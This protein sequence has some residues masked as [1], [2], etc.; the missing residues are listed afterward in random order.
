MSSRASKTAVG[1]LPGVWVWWVAAVDALIVTPIPTIWNAWVTLVDRLILALRESVLL[2]SLF[3]IITTL[4]LYKAVVIGS[5]GLSLAPWT[6]YGLVATTYLI[7]RIP[8]SYLY[9][10]AH[11]AVYPATAY[12]AVTIVIAAKNERDGIFRTIETCMNS[13]YAGEIECIA[14]DDGSTDGTGDE[15]RRAQRV[16]G[17]R[18]RLVLFPENLGKREAMARG[19]K[20]A[21]HEIIVFVDSDSF[22]ARDA[23][24]H[25]TEHFLENLRIGAVSGNTKVE[26]WDVNLLTRMQSIQYAVSFD[27]YKASE[28]VHRSVTCCPGCFSAY[29][30]T[31]I[32]PLVEVWRTHRFFGSSS[33]FGDDRGLTNFVLKKWDIVYCQKALAS[34]AVPETFSVYWKQQLRW[35]KSWIRE[36]LFASTFIWKTRPLLASFAF[37]TNFT[38]PIVGPIL[39]GFVLIRSIVVGDPLLFIVF[40]TGFVLL[41]VVFSLFARVYFKAEN[42]FYMPLV[43]LMFISVFIW[44]MPYALATLRNTRWGTR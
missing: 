43:S 17:G 7:T 15:M 5:T 28:S 40:M 25:I 29:R 12:P 19:I 23:L 33:T 4:L 10:D 39:A 3:T 22:L 30:R 27:I 31:A 34:T 37:Y 9:T 11:T 18:V 2:A 41:G 20:D 42:W 24:T 38:F 14:I 35:K 16:F 36:G 21:R 6:L 13:R 8:Y 26:N 32:L 1:G 44:Q